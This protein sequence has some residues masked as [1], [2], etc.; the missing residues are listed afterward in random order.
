MDETGTF[1]AI[2]AAPGNTALVFDD[3]ALADRYVAHRARAGAVG[4]ICRVEDTRTRSGLLVQ[5]RDPVPAAELPR[6]QSEAL[7]LLEQILAGRAPRPER[8]VIMNISPQ[9]EALRQQPPAHEE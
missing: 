2:D 9:V 4:L 7:W 3:V 8:G 6:R 5:W 1:A